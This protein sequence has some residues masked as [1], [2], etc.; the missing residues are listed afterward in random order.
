MAPIGK[1]YSARGMCQTTAIKATAAAAGLEL[2]EP[3]YKH[4]E[5]NKKPDF[6]AKFPHGKIPA[7]EGAN[8]LNLTEGAAIARYIAALSPNSGLLGGTIE[9]AALVDQYVHFAETEI[10]S[11]N[12]LIYMMLNGY[13]PYN[14]AIH[15]VLTERQ[16]RGYSTL[17]TILLTRTYLVGERLTLADITIASVIFL[18]VSYTLDAP[19]RARYPN[20]LRHFDLIINQPKLKEVFGQPTFVEKAVQ[21]TPPAKEKKEKEPK[22]PAPAP[23]PKKEKPKKAEEDDEEDEN[24]VPEEPKAKNPL[25]LLPKSTFNLE[26]WKRAYSNKD[27]RGPGGSLEW[28]YENFDKEGFSVYRVDF[29]YNEELT[30]VFMSSNQIGGFFNRLEA[31]RKYLFGSMGVLGAANDSIIAG[32]LILRG[33]DVKPVVE[34]AP[35]YESYDYRKLDLENSEDK[36]FFEG[37]LA[38]DLEIDGK[39]WQDGKNFK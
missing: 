8:G 28:F 9:D 29:K 10:H 25:D 14:K 16:L 17:E 21:Y 20:I 7:F 13:V 30:L 2:E 4:Y 11:S 3:E 35:D 36:A 37:A 18:S 31:S 27:T 38:W 22:Q 32:V 12:E 39:K 34:V 15:T 1:L 19:L 6:L 5:D 26:D 33:Q 24:L 23:A